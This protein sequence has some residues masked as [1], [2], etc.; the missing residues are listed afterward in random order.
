MLG[1]AGLE[2]GRDL[3]GVVGWIGDVGWSGHWD[4][5]KEG[6]YMKEA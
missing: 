3:G 6:P 4:C 5:V 2:M 1:G